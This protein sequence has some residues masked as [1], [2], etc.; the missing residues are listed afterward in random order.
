MYDKHG[1]NI[2]YL[3]LSVNSKCNFDCFFCSS[4]RTI[5]HELTLNELKSFSE[6]FSLLGIEHVR[7][8]GGEPLIRQ[9]LPQILELFSKNF[10]ISITTNGSRL[11]EFVKILSKFHVRNIN[12]S[13]H[14]LDEEIFYKITKAKLS[15]VL[16]GLKAALKEKL[17]IKLNCV[18]NRYNV[19]EIPNLVRFASKL[20][21][22][23]RFI[24]LMPI[25]QNNESVPLSEIMKCLESFELKPVNVKLGFGP[26]SYYVTKNGNYV[27]I[28]AALSK[29]F[30]S[31]CNKIRVSSEGKLYPCLGSSFCI[32][33]RELLNRTGSKEELL[34]ILRSIVESKPLRHNMNESFVQSNMRELGG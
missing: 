6:L 31:S 30:C 7:I 14:S 12:L 32:D 34:M 22:P 24:E 18:V 17:N 15:D 16:D 27:G 26:A 23:I 21:I 20:K 25:G 3:R 2:N 5:I 29:N 4:N 11:K 9:D 19:E 10:H 8:T 13:L 28:I 1:R 33:L